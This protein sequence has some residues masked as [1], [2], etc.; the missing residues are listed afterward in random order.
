MDYPAVPP[1]VLIYAGQR[2]FDQR[3]YAHAERPLTAAS[4]H[5]IPPTPPP[6]WDVLG[7]SWMALKEYKTAIE[8]F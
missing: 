4:T 1:Q 3:D 2:Q 8:A 5:K 7:Q 6:K